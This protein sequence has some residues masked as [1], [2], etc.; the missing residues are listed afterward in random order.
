MMTNN[1]TNVRAESFGVITNPSNVIGDKYN[2]VDEDGKVI[3]T[4][5]SKPLANV[6]T[7]GK[8][9]PFLGKRNS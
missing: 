2:I 7:K 3:A 4:T 1:Y 5:N 8:R 9:L 6:A